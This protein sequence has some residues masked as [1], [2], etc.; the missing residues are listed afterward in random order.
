[1][2]VIS[3]RSAIFTLRKVFF[4]SFHNTG[5]FSDPDAFTRKLKISCSTH[6]M[7]VIVCAEIK[8]A[9]H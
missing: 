8:C 7:S 2:S 3:E 1:M 9:L 4:V 6:S 5:C